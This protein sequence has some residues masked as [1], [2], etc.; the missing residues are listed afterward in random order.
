MYIQKLGIPSVYDT[1][2]YS[3]SGSTN[4]EPKERDSV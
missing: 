3:T 4:S 2:S 1:L